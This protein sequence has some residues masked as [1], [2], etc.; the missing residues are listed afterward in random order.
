MPGATSVTLFYLGDELNSFW[1]GPYFVKDDVVNA[2]ESMQALSVFEFNLADIQSMEGME[3][4][5]SNMKNNDWNLVIRCRTDNFQPFLP[6]DKIVNS[7]E[8][9]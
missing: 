1:Y 4:L 7:Y 6:G 5:A 3:V 9:R 8:S 2:Q